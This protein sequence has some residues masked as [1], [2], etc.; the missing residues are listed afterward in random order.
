MNRSKE[1]ATEERIG[2]LGNTSRI[3]RL[4]CWFRAF[5][6]RYSRAPILTLADFMN[7]FPQAWELQRKQF[8]IHFI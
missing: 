7:P 4:T 2:N 1:T 8:G 5:M 3:L 6:R